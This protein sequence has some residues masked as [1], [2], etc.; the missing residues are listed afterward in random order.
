M[1]SMAVAVSGPISFRWHQARNASFVNIIALAVLPCSMQ[2]TVLH[3]LQYVSCK[4]RNAHGPES[5]DYVGD[6]PIFEV[7]MTRLIVQISPMRIPWFTTR[8]SESPSTFP[9]N[10]S[11]HS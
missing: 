6:S 4:S 10:S 3:S 2:Q 5:D 9:K 7:M 11:A 8:L 1:R